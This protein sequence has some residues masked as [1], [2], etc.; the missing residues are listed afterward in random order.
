[1]NPLFD[2]LGVTQ[3]VWNE[4]VAWTINAAR[5]LRARIGALR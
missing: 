4:L 3:P 5:W 2:I 1:M